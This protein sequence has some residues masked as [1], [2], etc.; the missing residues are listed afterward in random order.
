MTGVA[1][2]SDDN[3]AAAGVSRVLQ[4]FSAIVQGDK[5]AQL[6]LTY[7]EGD[8][9]TRTY[10]E[11]LAGLED[12]DGGPP[13]DGL[14]VTLGPGRDGSQTGSAFIFEESG[15]AFVGIE[16][17]PGAA[18]VLQPA[19]VHAGDCP[20]TGAVVSPLASVL[21][22]SSFTILSLSKAELLAGNFAINVHKSAAESA[23]YVWRAARPR[24]AR[25]RSRRPRSSASCSWGPVPRCTS[26][27]GRTDQRAQEG[28]IPR[29]PPPP[30]VVAD[31]RRSDGGRDFPVAS[32]G[33]ASA[34]PRPLLTRRVLATR[35]R[36]GALC[37]LRGGTW[38]DHTHR[39]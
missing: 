11:Y 6:H 15:L 27:A 5:I 13:L 21:D 9:Q 14:E 39:A 3:T 32:A 35:S 33:C 17:A 12:D 18:G 19:H 25:G 8:A 10:L 16:V 23:V 31:L 2:V 38:H 24:A 37:C 36:L 29:R 7:E 1:L 26:R 4:P 34:H 22:G 20:G 28:R 30:L